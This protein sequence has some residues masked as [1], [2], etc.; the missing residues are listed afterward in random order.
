MLKD[1]TCK[2]YSTV[3]LSACDKQ[4][5]VSSDLSIPIVVFEQGKLKKLDT[6]KLLY[7]TLM[8]VQNKQ[9]INK[10]S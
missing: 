2:F 7:R 6:E 4:L 5:T 9:N 1:C 10:G 3:H 8:T